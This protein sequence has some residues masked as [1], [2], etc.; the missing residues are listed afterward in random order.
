MRGS[1]MTCPCT[2]FTGIV[3][4][5]LQK[6]Q[7]ILSKEPIGKERLSDAIILHKKSQDR[8]GLPSCS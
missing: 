5:I 6:L 7:A 2:D 3:C 1:Q 4:L 8:D